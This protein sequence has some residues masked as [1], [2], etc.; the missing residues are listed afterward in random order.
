M[1]VI[2]T[3]LILGAILSSS[4]NPKFYSS[5]T[6]NVPLISG[7]GETNL[8]LAGNGNQ[9]EFQG[10][11]GLS[12]SIS[13]K[14]N[15]SFFIPEDLDNGDGGSGKYF[16]AGIGYFRALPGNFVFENYGI[17]GFGSVE[18][19]F[20]STVAANPGTTGKVDATVFRYGIN[21]AFGYK[22][23]KFSAAVSSRF[24]NL[25]YSGISGSLIYDG[26]DQSDYLEENKSNILLEPA[27]TL[28]GG[29]NKIKLQVQYGY[30][31]NLSN[32]DFRQDKDYVTIGLNFNFN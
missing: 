4:C 6:Q 7:E 12:P 25:R 32:Q 9:V 2:Y 30:S 11:Y 15:G 1:K 20:P 24:S 31:F 18:N 22:T 13:I 28:R 17:I 10:A 26:V 14:G 27:I 19:H 16:E 3:T 8:T 21:P 23:S 5:N 29:F